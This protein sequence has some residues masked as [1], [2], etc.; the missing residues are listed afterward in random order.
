[1]RKIIN[2]NRPPW[3]LEV[4]GH[5]ILVPWLLAQRSSDRHRIGMICVNA[6]QCAANWWQ[7]SFLWLVLIDVCTWAIWWLWYGPCG[8]GLGKWQWID[9]IVQDWYRIG[10]LTWIGDILANWWWIGILVMDWQICD[11]LEN[12]WWIGRLVI[13]WQ[14]GDGLADW[15]RIGVW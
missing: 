13:D 1:M 6:C 11:I 8:I 10:R 15:Y 4:D 7:S 2:W 9:I 3:R 12:W 14:I 5:R